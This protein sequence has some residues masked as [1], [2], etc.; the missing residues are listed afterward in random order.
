MPASTRTSGKAVL[1]LVFGLSS[2]VC[3]FLALVAENDLLLVAVVL[4]AIA[5]VVL[6]V[7]SRLEIKRASGSL[8]GKAL[9]GWGIGTPVGGFGLAFLIL[10]M[11]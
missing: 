6:G 3:G 4:F 9:V 11:T 5:A 7:L 2:L 1:T 10:P 8:R